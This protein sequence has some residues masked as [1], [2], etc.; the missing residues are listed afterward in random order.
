[1]I[2]K[3][4]RKISGGFDSSDLVRGKIRRHF[5][6]GAANHIAVATDIWQSP[7]KQKKKSWFYTV[8]LLQW[9]PYA[10]VWGWGIQ[11]AERARPGRNLHFMCFLQNQWYDTSSYAKNRKISFVKVLQS[12]SKL[13]L[14]VG[15]CFRMLVVL[16]LPPTKSVQESCLIQT[17]GQDVDL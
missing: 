9:L 6:G 12:N 1:M 5:V 8:N 14:T 7:D 13:L 3:A 2:E 10:L 11:D 15:E 17:P 16:S 4:R